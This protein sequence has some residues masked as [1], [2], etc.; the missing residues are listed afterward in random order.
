MIYKEPTIG[1]TYIYQ[2]VI[3]GKGQALMSETVTFVDLTDNGEYVFKR[4][5]RTNLVLKDLKYVF[6]SNLRPHHYIGIY[7]NS[8]RRIK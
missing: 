7:N 4:P 8:K 3:P 6:P 2:P 5:D 1:K